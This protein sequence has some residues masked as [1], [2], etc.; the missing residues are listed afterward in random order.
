MKWLL[1]LF[2]FCYSCNSKTPKISEKKATTN[3]NAAWDL[4]FDT[5]QDSGY[6]KGYA[7]EKIK[8]FASNA[9]DQL[10]E[11]LD[12]LIKKSDIKLLDSQTLSHSAYVDPIHKTR[13]DTLKN[14]HTMITSLYNFGDKISQTIIF[15]GSILEKIEWNR[16]DSSW[17]DVLDL[18]GQSFRHFSFKGE[19]FYYLH[20]QVMDRFA[21]SIHTLNYHIIFKASKPLFNTLLTC[22]FDKMLVG[23]VNGDK[24]LDYLDFDNSDFCSGVPFSDSVTIRFYS[25]NKLGELKLQKDPNGKEYFIKGNT[26]EQYKQDSFKIKTKYWPF[27]IHD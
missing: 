15:N 12:G 18:D 9:N 19:D 13:Y 8:S 24:E 16:S 10:S 1:F 17:K 5:E 7:S 2:F 3:N 6:F 25:F 21:G 20:A 22:R 23:D 26:G 4:P 11:F 14:D 27:N